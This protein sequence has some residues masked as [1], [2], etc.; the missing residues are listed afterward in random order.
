MVSCPNTNVS[1]G[2]LGV[3]GD[4]LADRLGDGVFVG[5]AAGTPDMVQ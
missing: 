4:D 1:C 3:L 2:E 5:D